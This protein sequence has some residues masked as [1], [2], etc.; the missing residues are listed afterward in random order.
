MIFS[1]SG[2]RIARMKFRITEP[3][4]LQGESGDGRQNLPNDT[5][6]GYLRIAAVQHNQH[7]EEIN[8][9]FCCRLNH[10]ELGVNAYTYIAYYVYIFMYIIDYDVCRNTNTNAS[11][12]QRLALALPCPSRRL[13][14]VG[15]MA[16]TPSALIALTGIEKRRPCQALLLPDGCG[17]RRCSTAAR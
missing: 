10:T 3:Q 13:T 4:H 2:E 15:A 14:T 1:N 12:N 8:A 9:L 17:T 16:S 5:T 6:A 7:R 11:Q